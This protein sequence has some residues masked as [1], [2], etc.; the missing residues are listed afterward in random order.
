MKNLI[1]VLF[2]ALLQGAGLLA[3]EKF[4]QTDSGSGDEFSIRLNSSDNNSASLSFALPGFYTS[5]AGN[6][7]SAIRIEGAASV[8][9]PG[10]AALPVI[11]RFVQI[12]NGKS[13]RLVI[14]RTEYSEHENYRVAP[15][16]APPLRS[17]KAGQS[18][19]TEGPVSYSTDR[20]SPEAAVLLKEIAVMR[21]LR[22]AVIN[23]NPV[24]YNPVSGKIR[25]Y[26]AIDF[27]LFYEGVSDENN[28]TYSPQGMSKSF[29]RLYREMVL[30]YDGGSHFL[31]APKLL[32]LTADEL[33]P[34]IAPLTQWK[35]RKG[36]K[37][38]VVRKSDITGNPSPTAEQV[39]AYL[40]TVYNSP[41]RP[42]FVLLVGDASGA[43]TFPW[44]SASGGK[45]DHPYQ[46]LDGSDILPDIVV[47]RISV[48]TLPELDSAVAKLVQYE[49]QPNMLQTEWY[50]RAIVL[51]SNDGIDPVNGQVARDVFLNEG[52]FTNVAL[53]NNTFTQSQITG[54]INEGVSW[55]W[56]IGHGSATSWADPVW[57]MSNMPGFSFGNRQPSI[58][59]IACSN[60][61]LDFS[62]T[63]NCF[64]EGWIE[65]ER[66]N[67]ASNIAASTELCAFYTTDT[68]G[69]E[70][71]YAYFRHGI[72][73]F[74]S[75]LN[76]GKVKAYQYFNGNG[77][78]VET[79]NQF[80]ALGDPSQEA[81]SDMPKTAVVTSSM[82]GNNCIVN[83]KA[84]GLNLK[85]SLVAV[86]QSDSLKTSGYTDSL[87][88][89]TFDKSLLAEALPVTGV[90]TGKNLHPYEGV[91][92]LTSLNAF[93]SEISGFDLM[94][95]YP[96][97]F[98]PSTVIRFTL[99]ERSFTTLSVY[100]MLGKLVAQP[101]NGYLTG[102]HYSVD[103]NA[104]D[105][106]GGVY[107]FKMDADGY[108][109]SLK[110]I[111]LK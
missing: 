61:D 47:G 60:A 16:S 74:G 41:D 76:F 85:G 27:E 13:V 21:D 37:T 98:N 9:D 55:I 107:I 95:N 65:R 12:P 75:M 84:L 51:H 57:S 48:Q 7:Y 63:A 103:F 49:K 2:L 96:N 54:L 108:S 24:Q 62:A 29:D 73:D 4:T 39:K 82:S 106:S 67:S 68:I 18:S 90:V 87:G 88:N 92:M 72:Y 14:S 44:F 66:G 25:V 11:S 22:I 3:A 105:L 71:L 28:V 36:M 56:F 38:T 52:G 97:P 79:I 6:G 78:V 80:M 59:S 93:S 1:L 43:S 5:D 70:M 83:V 46:C 111:L 26:S 42:D 64:G 19:A 102:G 32:V 101:V 15:Y 8:G 94:Q 34:G 31:T 104:S 110:M 40:T 77:T 50:K 17:E 30:N 23:I 69:R 99:P 109:K 91:L 33:Q 58:V 81:F 45:S 20:Y 35:Q 10:E 86:H 89:F 53:V 100:D